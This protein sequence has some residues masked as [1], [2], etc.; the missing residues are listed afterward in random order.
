MYKKFSVIEFLIFFLM[1]NLKLT[2]CSLMQEWPN[3]DT[4]KH[5]GLSEIQ[6]KNIKVTLDS[7]LKVKDSLSSEKDKGVY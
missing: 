3:E 7:L 2:A 1:F 5:Y 4:L 6:I